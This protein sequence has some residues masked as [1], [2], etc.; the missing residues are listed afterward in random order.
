MAEYLEESRI[1]KE[2]SELSNKRYR[3]IPTRKDGVP[4]SGFW[5]I[6]LE[7]DKW[8]NFKC[9]HFELRWDE[10]KY[11]TDANEIRINVHLESKEPKSFFEKRGC[12]FGGEGAPNTIKE[13]NG[14]KLDASVIPDFS[15]EEKAIETV[16]RIIAA[17]DSPAYQQCADIADACLH[18]M[19]KGK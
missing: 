17:L 8:D 11:F 15:S 7:G 10:H 19:K 5:N 6:I 2:L 16:R 18:Q 1:E 9:F 13:V 14:M 12:T 3:F 4:R